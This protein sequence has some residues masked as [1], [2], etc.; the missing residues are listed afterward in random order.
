MYK[1]L[2]TGFEPF[3]GL[4]TNVSEIVAN[5]LDSKT[6]NI[7]L[8]EIGI[9][10]RKIRDRN[11]LLSVRSEILTVDR[12]G[13]NCIS[14]VLQS[15]SINDIDAIIHLGLARG[16]LIPRIETKGLNMNRFSSPDN[17]GR[18]ANGEIIPG[19]SSEIPISVSL[20]S[21]QNENLKYPFEFSEDA[22]GFVCNE[23]LF[24][25]LHALQSLDRNLPCIFVHLPS[26]ETMCID[27]QIEFVS[28][29]SGIIVQPKHIDV[30]AAIFEDEGNWFASRRK[31]P[32]HTDKWEFPG[33]KIENGETEEASL[34]RECK[35]E[36]DWDITPE[37]KILVID[38]KYPDFTVT[39][40]FWRCISLSNHPPANHSHTEHRW[41]KTSLLGDFDWLDAD[42]PL[43]EF[44]QSGFKI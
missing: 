17:E 34:V 1:I 14:N 22:G 23:T 42:I 26:E 4:E 27:E 43:I 38:H 20:E 9:G 32:L 11:P 19:A 39:I 28:L 10:I 6:F 15:D 31:G 3:A 7:N 16:A 35:E 13:S 40:H 18:I 25:T 21:L 8:G 36:L 29:I 37:E 12:S 44:I 2:I 41:I 24:N 5:S 30:V 33:G